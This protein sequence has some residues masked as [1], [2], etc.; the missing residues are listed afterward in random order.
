MISLHFT[1]NEN[2]QNYKLVNSDY[3]RGWLNK[4][5][6]TAM[7]V[8]NGKNITTNKHN[9]SDE[10]RKKINKENDKHEERIGTIIEGV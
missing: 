5:W 1:I 2:Y 3:L 7:C 8:G 10:R 9:I 4:T 6:S